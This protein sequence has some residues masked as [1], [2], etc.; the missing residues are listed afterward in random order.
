MLRLSYFLTFFLCL[1]FLPAKA[2]FKLKSQDNYREGIHFGYR[3]DFGGYHEYSNLK[4]FYNEQRPWLD[5]SLS[6]GTWLHG[7]DIGFGTQSDFGGATLLNISYA[8][9]K[10]KVRGELPSGE[11]FTRSVR[12]SQFAIDPIDAWWTPGHVGGFDMGFGVM[13]MGLMWCRFKT[14]LNGERPELGPFA[15]GSFS[16]MDVFLDMDAYSSFHIDVVRRSSNKK[17]GI[18]FQLFYYLG[19]KS[20]TNDLI[21]LNRELNPNSF[22]NYRQR[23][24]LQNSH[25]GIKTLL[26][27]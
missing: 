27:I 3:G 6:E 22:Q 17:T 1:S 21:L 11:A 5:N 15:K 24:L 23:T 4:A 20:K 10:D 13:P 7:F 25:F 14:K 26:F 2:Q 12:I 8:T 9:R 18:R 19:W 16:L